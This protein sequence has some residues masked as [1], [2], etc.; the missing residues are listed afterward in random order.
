MVNTTSHHITMSLDHQPSSSLPELVS[1]FLASHS[2][3]NTSSSAVASLPVTHTI[4][5]PHML[6]A[7]LCHFLPISSPF[8][9][10]GFGPAPPSH[11]QST[12]T[13]SATPSH[14]VRQSHGSH[15]D[16]GCRQSCRVPSRMERGGERQQERGT[17]SVGIWSC[18]GH[19]CGL[20]TRISGLAQLITKQCMV[21]EDRSSLHEA[22]HAFVFWTGTHTSTLDCRESVRRSLDHSQLSCTLLTAASAQVKSGMQ[23]EQLLSSFSVYCASDGIGHDDF[24]SNFN[25]FE[26]LDMDIGAGGWLEMGQLQGCWNIMAG[27]ELHGTHIKQGKLKEMVGKERDK[28]T[29]ASMNLLPSH[30]LFSS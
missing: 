16:T 23:H 11:T 12:L 29:S 7:F 18:S 15:Q 2:S 20:C 19:T 27:K 28:V 13:A 4:T 25:I 24:Y 26:V 21:L 10:I 5:K 6:A 22:C 1:T 3:A 9:A 8:Q 30:S 14:L 17:H